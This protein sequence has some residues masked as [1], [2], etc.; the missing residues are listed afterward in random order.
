VIDRGSGIPLEY[1]SK[2]FDRFFRIPGTERG[3]VGLGL[4]IAREIVLSHGGTIG[5]ESR[6]GEGS[7]F[8]FDLPLAE[9]K[10]A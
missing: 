4:A 7:E 3:G 8:Y 5:L 2:I 9:R 6:A 10:A 1:Q